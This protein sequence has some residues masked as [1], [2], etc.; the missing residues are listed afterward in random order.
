ME[1]NGY[2]WMGAG[3]AIAQL[4]YAGLLWRVHLE[5]AWTSN[6]WTVKAKKPKVNKKHYNF[7][8]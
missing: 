7:Q 3:T 8:S 5:G 1:V 6:M 4:Y 2:Y